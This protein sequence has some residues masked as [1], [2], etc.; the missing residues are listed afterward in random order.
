MRSWGEQWFKTVFL[1][2]CGNERPQLLILDGHGS[3]ET[4]GL[5]ELAAQEGIH[6]LALPPHTTHFLQPLDRSVFGPFNK[7][8]NKFCSDF[9]SK[10]AMNIINKWTFPSLFKSAQEE[11]ITSETIVSG[12]RACGIYPFNPH[13]IPES[14]YLPSLAYDVPQYPVTTPNISESTSTNTVSVTAEIHPVPTSTTFTEASDSIVSTPGIQSAAA[15]DAGSQ[16]PPRKCSD[17]EP[18]LLPES[19]EKVAPVIHE[20]PDPTAAVIPTEDANTYQEFETPENL[21]TLINMGLIDIIQD[22][23]K[24]ESEIEEVSSSFWNSEIDQIFTPAAA[25]Q[26]SEKNLKAGL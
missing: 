26:T 3:H 24:N 13:A 11:G 12:F 19:A 8:Y 1:P 6:V 14:A 25:V 16:P 7:A 10:S 15:M 23:N 20:D 4:L 9:L 2:N 22:P 21:L 17:S 18:Q 5:L